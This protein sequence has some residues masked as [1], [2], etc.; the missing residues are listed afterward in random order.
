MSEATLSRAIDFNDQL[1]ALAEIGLPMDL[2]VA[3]E[4]PILDELQR[5]SAE[6]A[7]QQ[8]KGVSVQSS[9]ADE[10]LPSKYRAALQTWLRC[11]QPQVVFE[12]ITAGGRDRRRVGSEFGHA[13]IYPLIITLIAFIGFIFFCEYLFP[14]IDAIYRQ[15]N[16]PPGS[17][18]A[19]LQAVRAAMPIW[20]VA[21]PTILILGIVLWRTYASKLSWRWLP[22]SRQ[23]FGLRQSARYA[24]QMALLMDQ[25]TS[26]EQA[27]DILE[28]ISP[29]RSLSG[30]SLSRQPLLDWAVSGDIARSAQ[31]AALQFVADFYRRMAVRRSSMWRVVL[32]S[33]IGVIIASGFV[34]GYG[35]SLFV[36]VTDLM[37]DIAKV[38]NFGSGG[39]P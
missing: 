6:L 16:Q 30:R 13:L 1:I 4:T 19:W 14:K 24:E 10:R 18:I 38:R 20:I 15:L 37:Y 25:T 22:G 32:P 29:L 36:P 9:L 12:T 35:L 27:K 33:A 23:F 28:P 17:A 7:L 8:S 34:L 21:I 31:P 26:R 2:G 39:G 3:P 11:D 5:I